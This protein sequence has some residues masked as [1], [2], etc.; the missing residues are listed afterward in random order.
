MQ[1]RS[2]GFLALFLWVQGTVNGTE[3]MG[4]IGSAV[5][6]RCCYEKEL[7]VTDEFRVQW[8]I[9]GE[10][11]CLVDAYFPNE[12]QIKKCP[13]F[14]NRTRLS[15]R[16]KQGDFTLQ[17]FNIS[18]NDEHTYTCHVQKKINRIFTHVHDSSTTL[19]V[20]ANYS[21]PVLTGPVESGAE[22]TFTCNSSHG[23]PKP[24]VYWINQTDNSLLKAGSTELTPE[25][26]GTF[27]VS[28]TLTIKG[29][30]SGGKVGCVIENERLHENLTNSVVGNNLPSSSPSAQPETQAA[31]PQA[32]AVSIV[33]LPLAILLGIWWWYKRR[34]SLQQKYTAPAEM[35]D[36]PRPWTAGEIP[37]DTE[38]VP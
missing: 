11:S 22:V 30:S 34:W 28:S 3:V 37:G 32:V 26:S 1:T 10:Q 17:L 2:L 16:L 7:L 23:Y 36:F 14:S 29:A 24:N 12:N 4:I 15:D 8:Q 20:A 5:E 35:T 33:V 9:K 19:K 27:S 18:H 25:P 6:L 31:V 38:A 21:K 13:R